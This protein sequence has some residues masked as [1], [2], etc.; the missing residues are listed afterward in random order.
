[1][2]V[3]YPF[4]G[5]TPDRG[6]PLDRRSQRFLCSRLFDHPPK[7]A[8]LRRL[9]R[10]SPRC[11]WNLRARPKTGTKNCRHRQ[12]DEEIYLAE[13][14]E[15]YLGVDSLLHALPWIA[16]TGA[17]TFSLSAPEQGGD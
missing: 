13:S 6:Y 1:M 14:G 16:A 8:L 17:G 2:N 4:S 9:Q 10:V 12:E 5:G 7:T 3:P 15:N 11:G